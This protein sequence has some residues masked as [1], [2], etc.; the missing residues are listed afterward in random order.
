MSSYPFASERKV[1]TRWSFRLL[2]ILPLM[3]FS[4]V[5]YKPV[6]KQ[7]NPLVTTSIKPGDKVRVVLTNGTEI[8]SI[9]VKQVWADSLLLGE[10]RR[11]TQ[12]KD[13]QDLRVRRSNDG[14]TASLIGLGL[15]IGLVI[16]SMKNV[17]GGVF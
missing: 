10:D 8:A 17:G 6:A 1:L 2:T 13:I 15:L 3:L 11:A 7:G 9:T 16:M 12:L 4:C 14:A 5:T